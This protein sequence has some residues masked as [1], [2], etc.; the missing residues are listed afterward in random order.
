[1]TFRVGGHR[2]NFFAVHET[3]E[4]GIGGPDSLLGE[5]IKLRRRGIE[6]YDRRRIGSSQRVVNKDREEVAIGRALCADYDA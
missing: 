3:V 4:R 5:R 2:Q 1:M 6:L